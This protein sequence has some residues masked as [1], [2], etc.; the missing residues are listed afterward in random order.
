MTF[1]R[2]IIV[3]QIEHLCSAIDTYFDDPKEENLFEN[4]GSYGMNIEDMMMTDTGQAPSDNPPP[5]NVIPNPQQLAQ[6]NSRPSK[7]PGPLGPRPGK[8]KPR[9]SARRSNSEPILSFMRLDSSPFG[10]LDNFFQ[11]RNIRKVM[12]DSNRIGY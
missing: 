10:F 8:Y 1:L 12:M 3:Y 7:Y 5:L 4:F 11:N 9:R 2:D 6:R